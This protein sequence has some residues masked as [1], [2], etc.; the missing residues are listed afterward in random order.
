MVRMN[1]LATG[2]VDDLI[3]QG[4]TWDCSER[5]E[6]GICESHADKAWTFFAKNRGNQGEN[7]GFSGK[8]MIR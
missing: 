5:G 7:R 6:R 4:D 2:D 3:F 8:D 1:M